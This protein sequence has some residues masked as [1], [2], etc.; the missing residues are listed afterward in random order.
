L[1]DYST[2]ANRVT[3]EI[4]SYSI[5]EMRDVHLWRWIIEHDRCSAQSL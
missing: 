1:H 3:L 5:S 4:Y 2:R